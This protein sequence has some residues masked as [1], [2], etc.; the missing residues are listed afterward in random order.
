LKK[1]ESL[2]NPEPT[3]P[4]YEKSRFP[5][6]CISA[7]KKRD[8][9]L[10]KAYFIRKIYFKDHMFGSRKAPASLLPDPAASL[11]KDIFYI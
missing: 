7:R 3:S 4:V 6:Q 9:L 11:K 8:I 2:C 1:E 5:R 10:L